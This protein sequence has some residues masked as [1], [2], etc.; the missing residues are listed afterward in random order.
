MWYDYLV[1]GYRFKKGARDEEVDLFWI[2]LDGVEPVG[3]FSF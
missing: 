2:G 3:V 1:K